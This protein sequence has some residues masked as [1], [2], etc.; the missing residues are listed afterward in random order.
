MGQ[1]ADR[2]GHEGHETPG[3]EFAQGHG[4]NVGDEEEPTMRNEPG[5]AGLEDD[6][7]AKATDVP[8]RSDEA[9]KQ[10]SHYQSR[11]DVKVGMAVLVWHGN[12]VLLLKRAG[13]HGAGTWAP[14]GG[15]LTQGEDFE[16]G[17]IREV[18][19]ETGVTVTMSLQM[20]ASTMSPFGWRRSS[21]LATRTSM[22]QKSCLTWAGSIGTTCHSRAFSRWNTTLPDVVI[23]HILTITSVGK[24]GA[25]PRHGDVF[26]RYRLPRASR[27][28]CHWSRRARGLDRPAL[29]G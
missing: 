6:I 13:S 4:W 29:Q 16:E 26:T 27:T 2:V 17:A 20:R 11:S 5:L 12:Q 7:G 9:G 15:H 28:V 10:I 14:P 19:E 1:G 22:R 25:S 21:P 23:R 24:G 8:T 3:D 18:R